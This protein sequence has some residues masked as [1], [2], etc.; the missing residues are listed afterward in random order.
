MELASCL[1]TC[2]RGTRTSLDGV[3]M[4]DTVA[5]LKARKDWPLQ[6]IPAGRQLVLWQGRALD[7]RLTLAEQDVRT[8]VADGAGFRVCLSVAVN[9]KGGKA[10]A[11]AA[12]SPT[13]LKYI[14]SYCDF[15]VN[16]KLK[17]QEEAAQRRQ[18]KLR[19]RQE[20][21]Q[22]EEARRGQER[23]VQLAADFG[24]AFGSSTL[25]AQERLRQ[26]AVDHGYILEGDPPDVTTTLHQRD[27][28]IRWCLT[29][30][31]KTG[32]SIEHF[33]LDLQDSI[34]IVAGDESTAHT[35]EDKLHEAR[36]LQPGAGSKVRSLSAPHI[37][38]GTG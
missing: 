36:I 33:L 9:A 11:A 28:L 14:Q 10:A 5:L 16:A 29:S 38:H 12:V 1:V 15:T 20:A 4:D 19:R 13:R 22:R 27:W 17:S 2:M 30:L 25:E 31:A 23:L 21:R 18:E 34:G 3:R 8:E 6:G 7:N 35:F 26:T 37:V 32:G 24:A